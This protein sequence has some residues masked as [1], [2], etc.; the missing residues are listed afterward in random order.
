M[1]RYGLSI[2]ALVLTLV[3]F[4]SFQTK[5]KAAEV[6]IQDLIDAEVN[7]R[8]A[9][10]RKKRLQACRKKV[11]EEAS[12]QADSMIIDKVKNLTLLDT[13]LRPDRLDR[14]DRPIERPLKDTTPVAPLLPLDSLDANF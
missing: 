1:I 3:G 14:P 5:E 11:L 13:L 9:N 12:R 7:K 8:V 10:F 4:M 2:A 6:T